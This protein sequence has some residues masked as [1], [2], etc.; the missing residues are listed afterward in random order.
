MFFGKKKKEKPFD[1]KGGIE[2]VIL[3]LRWLVRKHDK[4]KERL[5]ALERRLDAAASM[6]VVRP[7]ANDNSSEPR[8]GDV[9]G[10]G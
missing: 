3:D 9:D 10:D 2:Q 8:G 5:V 6:A 1:A 4:L 7:G